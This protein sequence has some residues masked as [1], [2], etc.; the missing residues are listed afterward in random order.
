METGW[1]EPTMLTVVVGSNGQLGVDICTRLSNSNFEVIGVTHD[2]LDLPVFEQCED[3]LSKLSPQ[4]VVNTAA[5]HHV[6]SC[7]QNPA[8][9]FAVNGIGARNL[10]L[11]SRK[12]DFTLAHFSTDYVFDG[13]KDS[14]YIESDLPCPLNVY[15]NT[16]LS[17]EYFVRTLSDKFFIL[18]V[19]ALYGSNP[20][21]AKGGQNFINTMLRLGTERKEVS[22]VDD[23][24][25]S[26]TYTKNVAE[27]MVTL[28]RSDGYGLY[29]CTSQG[30]CSWF[31][32]AKNIFEQT[33][34]DVK[35]KPAEPGQ[36]PIKTP[37]PMWSVLENKGLK[38]SGMDIM[39][40]WIDGLKEY[41]SDH[42]SC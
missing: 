2:E 34:M 22:V 39:P 40:H 24:F 31:E 19:S 7:E 1:E 14:P 33:G 29:H 36:F 9:S 15:G 30:Y 8:L 25:V 20:C 28:L 10:A 13:H 11:L 18:R 16:K 38:D 17:G 35:V 12:L 32:F 21:R 42:S 27:Q 41:F 6:E 4:I 26:P 23:E 3:I 5:Y 37:R